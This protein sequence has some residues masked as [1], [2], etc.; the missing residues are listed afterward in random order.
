MDENIKI[1]TAV[2]MNELTCKI[3]EYNKLIE[4]IENSISLDIQNAANTGRYNVE[5]VIRCNNK[6][7]REDIYTIINNITTKLQNLGYV[8]N[9]EM[10]SKNAFKITIRWDELND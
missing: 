7:I 4:D 1:P 3:Q 9:H 6:S 8:V 10:L 5:R 2:E